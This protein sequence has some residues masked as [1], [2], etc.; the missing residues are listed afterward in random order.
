M[1]RQVRIVGRPILEEFAKDHADVRSAIDAW[2]AEVLAAQWNGPADVK[3]R[4]PHASIIGDGRVVFNL[5][6]NKYRLDT[7]MAYQT[8]VVRIVRIGT[9]AGYD[10]WTF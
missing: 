3:A 7:R 1:A 10:T 4:Y 8:K 2:V 6:G 9:H 5:K